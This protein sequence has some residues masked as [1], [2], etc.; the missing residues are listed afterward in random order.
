VLL[1]QRG[2]FGAD[3]ARET[4][5]ALVAQGSGVWLVA[6]VR[7]LLSMYYAVGDTRTPVLVAAT[8]LGAFIVLSLVLRGPLGHVGIGWAV[9]GASAVQAGLLWVLLA[10]KMPTILGQG[11]ATSVLRV[12]VAS[13]FAVA[14]ARK[15]AQALAAAEGAGGFERALP[16]VAGG[17]AFVACFLAVA[18]LVRSPELMVLV[19]EITR[20]LRRS[21][22]SGGP[23]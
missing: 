19:R 22:T 6:T 21:S 13:A 1:F 11:V 20:R 7:Q 5:R 15:V 16:G 18:L 3:S 4:A 14:A 10:R 9:T 12:C 17:A 2:E 8:D 23:T